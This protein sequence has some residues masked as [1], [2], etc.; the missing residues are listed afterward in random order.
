MSTLSLRLPDSLHKQLREL[1]KREGISINQF[2]SAAVGEKMA[3]LMTEEFLAKRAARGSREKFEAALA[4]IPD[5]E[6]EDYDR[7]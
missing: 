5:R 1:A 7:L 3:A 6:P 2:I 4:Q